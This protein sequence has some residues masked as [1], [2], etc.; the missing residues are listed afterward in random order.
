MFL[1]ILFIILIIIYAI[2]VIYIY[3]RNNIASYIDIINDFLSRHCSDPAVFN[4]KD[5]PWTKTFRDNRQVILDEYKKYTNTYIVPGYKKINT[6]T[7]SCDVNGGWKTL[8]LRIYDTNTTIT[9]LFPETMKLINEC[10]C[11]LAF[12]SM[13]EPNTK[14]V[15]H[16]GVYKGLLRYHLPLII[17]DEWD[18]CFINVN[19]RVLNWR[20]GEDLMFDDRFLHHAENNT[21]Q[22]RVILFLDIKRDFK[23]I[24]LNLLNTIVLKFIK[25]ND[26]LI[27]TVEKANSFNFQSN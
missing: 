8:F 22:Q 15:R 11:T 3:I 9:H 1:I 5:F 26:I 6:E 17:P 16:R 27:D 2:Y 13:F 23:S 24:W 20:I 18:K 7:S 14:L 4:S 10:S 25:S 12:F 21:N 19:G